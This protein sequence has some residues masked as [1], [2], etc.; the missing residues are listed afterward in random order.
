MTVSSTTNRASATGNGVTT[1]FSFGYYFINKSDL[2]VYVD[3]VLKTLNTDYTISG[4][5]PFPSGANVVFS[6]APANLAS[7]VII[8]LVAYT[9]TLDLVENDPLPAEDV[10]KRF[11]LNVMMCQQIVEQLGRMPTLSISSLYSN[12]TLTD[13]V[14]LQVLRWNAGLTGIESVPAA[15]A[16]LIT[17][18]VQ[19]GS[20]NVT[21]ANGLKC[22]YGAW[23]DLISVTGTAGGG[24]ATLATE[25]ASGAVQLIVATKGKTNAGGAYNGYIQGSL[26]EGASGH[27]KFKVGNGDPTVKICDTYW[28]PDTSF[29]SYPSGCLVLSSGADTTALTTDMI[30]GFISVES[31]LYGLTGANGLTVDGLTLMLGAKGPTGSIHFTTNGVIAHVNVAAIGNPTGNDKYNSPQSSLWLYGVANGGSGS[32]V[33]ATQG[34]TNNGT[35]FYDSNGGGY[36]FLTDNTVG[37][38]FK[39]IRT[40][41]GVNGVSLTNAIAGQ[42]PTLAPYGTSTNIGM[43]YFTKGTAQSNHTFYDGGRPQVQIGGGSSSVS[44]LS[45]GSDSNGVVMSAQNNGSANPTFTLYSVGTGDFNFLTSNASK[46]ILNLKDNYNVIIGNSAQATT[47]T[48][49]FLFLPSC[50]G[51]PTGVPGSIPS[52]RIA[53]MYDRTNNQI[54]M[55]NGAWKKTVALT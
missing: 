3:G 55:Y 29:H 6:V 32:A 23:T 13:P 25:G 41:S 39:L 9:Q 54:Y 5:G 20:N 16:G 36:E 49:G 14:A 17:S 28:N 52:N 10:E 11:D 47:D 19:D 44:Y 27:I 8:R 31:T 21:I 34:S 48:A 30:A 22:Y 50:A 12:L 37:R 38:L 15:S 2:A 33:I 1:S 24:Y 42:S 7:V 53:F 51:A 46:N 40:A 43:L 45:V 4:S 26:S 18:V 35:V